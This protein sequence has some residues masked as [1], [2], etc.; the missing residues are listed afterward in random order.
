MFFTDDSYTWSRAWPMS[1][2]TGTTTH[3]ATQTTYNKG[4]EREGQ[5]KAWA[6][7]GPRKTPTFVASWGYRMGA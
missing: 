6:Y 7:V 5:R 2:H 4:R 1:L 3:A